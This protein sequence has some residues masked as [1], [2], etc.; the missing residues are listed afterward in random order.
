MFVVMTSFEPLCVGSAG[1][2]PPFGHPQSFTRPRTRT[3]RSL[4]RA[5]HG[6]ML[7][8]TCRSHS[9]SRRD[10]KKYRSEHKSNRHKRVVCPYRN[11]NSRSQCRRPCR[12]SHSLRC[13]HI[14]SWVSTETSLHRRFPESLLLPMVVL[15]MGNPLACCCLVSTKALDR[16]SSFSI[17]HAP[18]VLFNEWMV[19]SWTLTSRPTVLL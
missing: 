16:E 15:A 10:W 9:R 14:R 6:S 4:H 12:S 7:R 5:S 8:S 1:V 18:G 3:S 11:S 19:V 13:K 17:T 2:E